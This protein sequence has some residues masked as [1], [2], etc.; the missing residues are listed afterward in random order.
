[1]GW[2]ATTE[3]TATAE[4]AVGSEE[5]DLDPEEAK[6]L[7]TKWMAEIHGGEISRGLSA[8]LGG[9][10]QVVANTESGVRICDGDG[11]V[12]SSLDRRLRRCRV[13][14]VWQPSG[15]FGQWSLS[16]RPIWQSGPHVSRALVGCPVREWP[17]LDRDTGTE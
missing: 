9:E 4:M 1:M 6:A 8:A 13:W 17:G 5:P 14:V 3:T 11:T 15:V 10:F 12:V 16:G 2:T 7:R